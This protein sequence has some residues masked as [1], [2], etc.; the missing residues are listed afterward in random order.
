MILL[1]LS[2]AFALLGFFTDGELSFGRRLFHGAIG[3]MA[4]WALA[5]IVVAAVLQMRL[6]A[7]AEPL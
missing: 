2:G 3:G 6:R 5:W 4:G 7:R 1:A